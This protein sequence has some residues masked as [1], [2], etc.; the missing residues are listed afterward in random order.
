MNLAKRGAR[1]MD[2]GIE[3]IEDQSVVDQARRQ[4]R[5]VLAKSVL[6]GAALTLAALLLPW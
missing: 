6:L 4:A 5:R 2:D 3:Q 1:N